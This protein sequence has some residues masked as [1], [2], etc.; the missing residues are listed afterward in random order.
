MDVLLPSTG[1]RGHDDAIEEAQ[2]ERTR[3]Q[4][5]NRPDK[6]PTKSKAEVA[7]AIKEYSEFRNRQRRGEKR[8]Y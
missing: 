8:F 2:I 3:Q 4:L 1:D 5:R 6:K 7:G